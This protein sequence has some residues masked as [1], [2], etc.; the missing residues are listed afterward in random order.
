MTK[1]DIFKYINQEVEFSGIR[2]TPIGI[3][4]IAT[5]LNSTEQEIKPLLD[6]LVRDNKIEYCAIGDTCVRLK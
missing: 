2:E 6:Q 4:D 1:T 5:G 3:D